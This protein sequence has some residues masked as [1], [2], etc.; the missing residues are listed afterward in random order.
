MSSHAAVHA[1]R[2][3]LQ[4]SPADLHAAPPKKFR[5]ENYCAKP[6][7]AGACESPD[8]YV[9]V[10]SEISRED[11]EERT[12]VWVEDHYK[13]EIIANLLIRETV[14]L[15]LG[16]RSSY[17]PHRHRIIDWMCRAKEALRICEEVH[18]LAVYFFDRYV[19]GASTLFLETKL[20]LHVLCCIQLAVERDSS[21][22][23]YIHGSIQRLPP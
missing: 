16:C 20:D 23:K 18:Q 14:R 12:P 11:D 21:R 6:S 8:E 10:N 9:T 17:T 4:M 3:K 2:R 15:P 13:N 19:D 7:S 22:H 5:I 1:A